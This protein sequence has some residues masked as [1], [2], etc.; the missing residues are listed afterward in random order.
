MR[1]GIKLSDIV[2]PA[3]TDHTSTSYTFPKLTSLR[4]ETCNRHSGVVV[5]GGR[6]Q[7]YYPKGDNS[8]F[9]NR[10]FNLDR[11]C[12]TDSLYIGHAESKSGRISELSLLLHCQ[13]GSFIFQNSRYNL[14]TRGQIVSQVKSVR[15]PYVF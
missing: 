15:S 11:L 1:K 3:R 2:V 12:Q 5:G 14:K 6:L 9:R 13:S 4:I 7:H 8:S 10:N